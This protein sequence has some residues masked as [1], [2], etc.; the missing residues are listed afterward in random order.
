M[1][2]ESR[3]LIGAPKRTAACVARS[4]ASKLGQIAGCVRSTT[5]YWPFL[6]TTPLEVPGHTQ[7]GASKAP[8]A[9]RVER[10]RLRHTATSLGR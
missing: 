10:L 2:G 1:T 5:G 3:L 8:R 6:G 9:L 7:P 4:L